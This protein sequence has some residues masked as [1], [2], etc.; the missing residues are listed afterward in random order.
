M[1]RRALLASTQSQNGEGGKW[2]YELHLTPEWEELG[3]FG[4]T[5]NIEGDFIELFE[6]LKTMA[7]TLGT[8]IGSYYD[9]QLYDIPEE[10][11][12]TVDGYRLSDVSLLDGRTVLEISFG[13]NVE[14]SGTMSTRLIVLDKFI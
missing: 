6:F 14:I 8:Y 4:S 12:I 10:C 2:A 7:M 11:N 13:L 5:T 3:F 9:Y 1:R